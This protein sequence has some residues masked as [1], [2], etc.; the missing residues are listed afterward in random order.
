MSHITAANFY[1]VYNAALKQ[2][3]TLKQWNAI[4]TLVVPKHF[5]IFRNNEVVSGFIQKHST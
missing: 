3:A 1:N 2:E 4:G 5:T